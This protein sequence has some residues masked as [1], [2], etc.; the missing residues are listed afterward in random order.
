VGAAA[1][2]RLTLSA[3]PSDGSRPTPL[4]REAQTGKVCRA[5]GIVTG[6]VSRF[7][8]PYVGDIARKLLIL[9]EGESALRCSY[10]V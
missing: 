5:T 4:A 8:R 3:S 6:I 10:K 7:G 2:W 9:A 1:G